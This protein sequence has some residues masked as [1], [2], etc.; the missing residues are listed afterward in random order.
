MKL[1][2]GRTSQ[3][4]CGQHFRNIGG[5]SNLTLGSAALELQGLPVLSSSGESLGSVHL[6]FVR[7]ILGS[8]PRQ[9]YCSPFAQG[10]PYQMGL[11][12]SPGAYPEYLC[13][14]GVPAFCPC[15]VPV[16]LRCGKRRSAQQREC[17]TVSRALHPASCACT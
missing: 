10:T 9:R 7:P 6:P 15:P 12:S 14:V 3:E 2:S 16:Q 11:G 17:S 5:A 8:C 13:S 1:R 4:T